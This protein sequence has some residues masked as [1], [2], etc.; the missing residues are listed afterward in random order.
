MFTK[1]L[2]EAAALSV[3]SVGD[4]ATLPAAPAGNP[5]S[6]SNI[7]TQDRQAIETAIRR[8]LKH[9]EGLQFIWPKIGR[10]RDVYCGWFKHIEQT[11][12]NS[13]YKMYFSFISRDIKGEI[14][15]V[16]V[17]FTDDR[18]G[19]FVQSSCAHFGFD[20]NVPPTDNFRRRRAVEAQ[21]KST[22]ASV[23]EHSTPSPSVNK[24]RDDSAR[25]AAPPSETDAHDT[26]MSYLSSYLK[27][28]FSAQVQCSPPSGP[29]WV[30]KSWLDRRHYG[31]V[32]RCNINAKNSFGGYAGFRPHIFIINGTTFYHVDELLAGWKYKEL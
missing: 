17:D 29:A 6:A 15:D 25:F 1:I 11:T 14:S 28:P 32:V 30:K 18:E 16:T 23:Q 8:K 19:S 9:P 31:Y 2:M 27:D 7:S 26:I 22:D 12:N 13:K 4:G 20:M 5:R 10:D 21:N 3:A 24:T